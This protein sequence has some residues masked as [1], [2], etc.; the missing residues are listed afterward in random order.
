MQHYVA[1]A[2]HPPSYDPL[3]VLADLG[4]RMKGE[5]GKM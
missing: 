3:Y 1:T 5:S 2:R 4:R